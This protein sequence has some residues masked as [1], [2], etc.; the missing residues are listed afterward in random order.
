ML[1]FRASFDF[2][3]DQWSNSNLTE[4][5]ISV[6]GILQISFEQDRHANWSH[7]YCNH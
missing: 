3:K 1:F 5:I 4:S 6:A 2:L 7:E